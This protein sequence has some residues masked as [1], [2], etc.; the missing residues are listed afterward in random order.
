MVKDL[1]WLI[2][3]LILGLLIYYSNKNIPLIEGYKSSIVN[4]GGPN[5]SSK[6]FLNSNETPFGISN[7]YEVGKIYNPGTKRNNDNISY[8]YGYYKS[9]E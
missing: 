3:L 7:V 4:I 5:I 9:D 1:Y 6:H 8:Y 2:I